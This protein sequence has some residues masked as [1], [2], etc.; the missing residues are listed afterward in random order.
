MIASPGGARKGFGA[1]VRSAATA[2]GTPRLQA[3]KKS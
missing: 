3:E 1:A 2:R